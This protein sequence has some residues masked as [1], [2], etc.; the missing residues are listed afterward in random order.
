MD[1]INAYSLSIVSGYKYAKFFEL[2]ILSLVGFVT[3][4]NLVIMN[5]D[6]TSS[7]F[8][9]RQI[10]PVSGGVAF[11]ILKTSQWSY[12]V[13]LEKSPSVFSGTFSKMYIFNPFSNEFDVTQPFTFDVWEPS[14]VAAFN[15]YGTPFLGVVNYQ[16]KRM[17]S[18]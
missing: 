16:D 12:L 2:G 3:E 13:V 17:Q 15:V 5:W 11:D 10:I 14:A 1:S 4:E 18:F 9:I 8:L 6:K 7:A